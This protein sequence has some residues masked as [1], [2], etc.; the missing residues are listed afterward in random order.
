M[1]EDTE[2]IVAGETENT[3]AGES[4]DSKAADTSLN[5]DGTPYL[6]IAEH[7]RSSRTKALKLKVEDVIVA[8][9]G[10]EF[11]SNSDNLVDLLSSEDDGQWLLTI[12]R[13]GTFFEVFTRGPL[14]GVLKFTSE[15]E[16]KLISTKFNDRPLVEKSEFRTFEVLKDI[17]KKCDVYDTTFSQ[18][19]VVLP[20]VW[21]AQNR[22]WEP[23]IAVMSVYLITFN[24]N[25]VLFVLSSLLIAVYFKQ[26]Q[27]TM[28]RSYSMFQDFQM[29]AIVAAT[30]EAT[31]QQKC[32]AFDPK[33]DFVRSL[34]GPPIQN[35][36]DQ[37]KKPK[38]RK[39]GNVTSTAPTTY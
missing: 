39:S 22:M 31:V 36:T 19:A 12:W 33:C 32:R 15:E 13:A 21:L 11:R 14:G 2:N 37:K 28:R 9:D 5:A 34:V 38:K 17:K 24:V 23:F 16:V 30:D 7:G 3:G 10:T 26:G 27:V 29:W 8:V 20:P 4:K 35:D 1:A 25:F 6:K 18:T